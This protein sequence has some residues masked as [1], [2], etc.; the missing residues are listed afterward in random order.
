MQRQ[1][2]RQ[3]KKYRY[4]KANHKSKRE[5]KNFRNVCQLCL[6]IAF[7]FDLT[8]WT[9]NNNAKRYKTFSPTGQ[10]AKRKEK[11]VIKS[12][13]HYTLIRCN[14][15]SGFLHHPDRSSFASWTMC[16]TARKKIHKKENSYMCIIIYT[17]NR[18]TSQHA[19]NFIVWETL[20][21]M[22]HIHSLNG[23]GVHRC[24]HITK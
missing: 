23:I 11:N 9:I 4:S 22:L 24:G 10:Y 6:W 12:S 17:S 14:S 15:S 2:I 18:H 21:C 13:N 8:I 20:R 3:P 1:L 19:Q 16:Q 5:I 7:M